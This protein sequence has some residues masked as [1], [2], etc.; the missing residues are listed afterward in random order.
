VTLVT[1]FTGK[2][3]ANTDRCDSHWPEMTVR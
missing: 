1:D 3:F 2:V